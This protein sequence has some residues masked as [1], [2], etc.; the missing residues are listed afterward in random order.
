[1]IRDL[2]CSFV[3]FLI[4]A[5]SHAQPYIALRGTVTP[6]SD[7]SLQHE[8]SFTVLFHTQASPVNSNPDLY[9]FRAVDAQIVTRPMP[10]LQADTSGSDTQTTTFQAGPPIELEMV[11]PII[12]PMQFAYL[13][14][15]AHLNYWQI[16]MESQLDQSFFL[17]N[18]TIDQGAFHAGMTSLPDSPTSYGTGSS[19]LATFIV[20]DQQS[21]PSMEAASDEHADTSTG[22]ILYSANLTDDNRIPD[23]PTNEPTC[24][25]DINGDGALNFQDISLFLWVFSFGCP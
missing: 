6:S 11:E 3:V 9:R 17:A 22:L 15:Y 8:L 13:E 2:A 23:E 19:L 18:F 25:P 14:Y 5:S 20:D 4:V 24:F 10:F 7:S 1:M 12:Y 21:S 16:R